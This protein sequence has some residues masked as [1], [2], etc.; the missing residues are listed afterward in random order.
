MQNIRINS[1]KR[2]TPPLNV[3]YK[4]G[5]R[6][7]YI[8]GFDKNEKGN[9]SKKEQE[10]LKVFAKGLQKLTDNEVLKRIKKGELIE[11]LND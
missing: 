9:I 6:L 8:Y 5:N 11:I 4:V 10:A 2:C 3:G 7:I 1:R